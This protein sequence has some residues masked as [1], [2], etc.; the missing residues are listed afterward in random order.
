MVAI[1]VGSRRLT[2]A[3]VKTTKRMSTIP[4]V[5]HSSSRRR[6]W[7]NG[8]QHASRITAGNFHPNFRVGEEG[9][10]VASALVLWSHAQNVRQRDKLIDARVGILAW[11]VRRLATG[12]FI[13]SFPRPGGG[14]TLFSPETTCFSSGRKN[15]FASGAPRMVILCGPSS[16]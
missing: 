16:R 1:A 5:F 13:V 14:T 7:P 2:F 15:A 10:A 4:S 6:L 9:S 8:D 3:A 11:T 12:F